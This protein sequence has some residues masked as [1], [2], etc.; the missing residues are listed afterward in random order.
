MKRLV[1]F[2][3]LATLCS[4]TLTVARQPVSGHVLVSPLGIKWGPAPPGLPPAR[5]RP[6]LPA[7]RGWPARCLPFA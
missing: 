7:T 2:V 3:G 5:K 6:C 1:L 4:G